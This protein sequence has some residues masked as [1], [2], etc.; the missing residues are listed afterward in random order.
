MVN[1][2]SERTSF[3]GVDFETSADAEDA[4]LSWYSAYEGAFTR[5]K[6]DATT[7]ENTGN[8]ARDAVKNQWIAGLKGVIPKKEEVPPPSDKKSVIKSINKI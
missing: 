2:A 8:K 7:E 5:A 6:P 4:V 1:Q 3:L